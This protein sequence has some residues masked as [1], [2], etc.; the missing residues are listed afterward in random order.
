MDRIVLRHALPGP[1]RSRW[2]AATACAVALAYGIGLLP[3]TFAQ[4]M[5]A[6][7][8]LLGGLMTTKRAAAAP[9]GAVRP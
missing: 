8:R 6:W 3:A 7:S 2:V 5:A 1:S 9:R 4:S